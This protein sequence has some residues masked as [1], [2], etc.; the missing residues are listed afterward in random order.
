MKTFF[1][2]L[3]LVVLAVVAIKLL[4]ITLAFGC[5]LALGVAV[6]AAIGV[7]LMAIGTCLGLAITA[8]LAPVWLP[9]LVA[10]GII[11]LIKRSSRATT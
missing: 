1:K 5:L 11:M 10:L 8:L 6:L 9:L 7:S 2:V 3:L 4:P